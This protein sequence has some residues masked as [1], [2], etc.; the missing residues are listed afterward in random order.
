MEGVKENYMG[1]RKTSHGRA[2]WGY[3]YVSQCWLENVTDGQFGVILMSI[4]GSLEVIVIN[5]LVIWN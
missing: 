4:M 3:C 1:L 2:M 5:V